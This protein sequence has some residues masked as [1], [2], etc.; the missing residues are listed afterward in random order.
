MSLF[1]D[2]SGIA[3]RIGGIHRSYKNYSEPTATREELDLLYKE[4]S[5]DPLDEEFEKLFHRDYSNLEPGDIISITRSLY[6]HFGVFIG[7][8][9]VIHLNEDKT[10]VETNIEGFK[11]NNELFIID[12]NKLR[13]FF[14]NEELLNNYLVSIQQ[15][16]LFNTINSEFND[17]NP[18]DTV[19]RAKSLL[20]LIDENLDFI[21]KEHFAVWCKTGIKECPQ[22]V[23]RPVRRKFI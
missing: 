15:S 17:F 21:N 6:D 22:S 7:D 5:K 2:I 1:D 8:N 23:L 16:K 19:Y 14:N 4:S 10:V 11:G 13:K 12:F 9:K 3:N 18:Q 20:G